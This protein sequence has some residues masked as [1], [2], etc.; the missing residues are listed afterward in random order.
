MIEKALASACAAL[1]ILCGVFYVRM[2]WAITDLAQYRAQVAEN[3]TRAEAE[4]RAKETAMRKQ[5]ER[6]ANEQA[7]KDTELQARA[8]A[9]NTAVVGLRDDIARLNAGEAASDS[10]ASASANGSSVARQLLGACANEYR[11]M[12]QSADRLRDQVSGLQ[13]YATQV[14]QAP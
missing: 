13:S 11:D 4:A 5:S 14:C 1:M 12:A 10:S 9:A 3:T 6:L 8:V 2:N 7:K